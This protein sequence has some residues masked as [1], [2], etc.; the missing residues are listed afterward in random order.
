MLFDSSGGIFGFVIVLIIIIV[1][2]LIIACVFLSGDKERKDHEPHK[3]RH[4]LDDSYKSNEGCEHGCEHH[5]QR[6]YFDNVR[7]G[8][9]H[10]YK[11]GR[12]PN[13][14]PAT[15]PVISPKTVKSKAPKSTKFV[16]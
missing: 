9:R 7:N 13:F 2:I 5:R 15:V 4:H 10:E 1:I 11:G 6:S 14:V 3:E 12:Q 16:R 8:S